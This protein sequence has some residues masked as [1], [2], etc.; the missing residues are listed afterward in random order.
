[1]DA[2]PL[3]IPADITPKAFYEEFL[4]RVF[5]ENRAKAAQ[6]APNAAQLAGAVRAVVDG[7][8][9]GTWTIQFGAGDMLVHA[10]AVGDALVTFSQTRD[11]WQVTITQGVG[12]MLAKLGSAPAAATGSGGGKGLTPAKLERLKMMKGL[13]KFELTGYEGSRT[14]RLTIT[15]GAAQDGKDPVCNVSMTANDFQDIS[16]GKLALQQAVMGGK[17][18]LSG[19]GVPF[20]M[21]LGATLMM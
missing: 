13:I 21:Q 11:D 10:G 1:M 4:P 2:A 20:A 8:G 18:K 9:G 14:L 5:A 7:D 19:P 3:E 12:K 16:A 15:V 6:L 17:V